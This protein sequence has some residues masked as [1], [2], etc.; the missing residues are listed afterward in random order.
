MA[1]QS[2]HCGFDRYIMQSFVHTNWIK[3][4]HY[5]NVYAHPVAVTRP[6]FSNNYNRMLI[7]T[8]FKKP[9]SLS[10]TMIFF[11]ISA[12]FYNWWAINWKSNW[13]SQ[14]MLTEIFHSNLTPINK[15]YLF[16]FLFD[17]YNLW[18]KEKSKNKQNSFECWKI[19]TSLKCLSA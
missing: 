18:Y 14:I 15:F 10:A 19:F 3:H 13:N 7:L 4:K 9:F 16:I 8:F 11:K 2:I 12:L 17:E 1:C 6:H 5:K